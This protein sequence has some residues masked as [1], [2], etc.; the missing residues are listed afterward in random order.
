MESL[1]GMDHLPLRH[2]CSYLECLSQFR[3]ATSGSLSG[4]LA[5]SIRALGCQECL[6]LIEDPQLAG[7]L[8]SQLVA[9]LQS[10]STIKLPQPLHPRT[11]QQGLAIIG[12]QV[13]SF[14]F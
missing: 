3:H 6:V 12:L 11:A 14:V 8:Q 10:R 7:H 4:Q 2:L 1:I 5:R 9:H 13:Q